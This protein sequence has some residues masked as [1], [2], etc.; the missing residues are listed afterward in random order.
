MKRNTKI[1]IILFFL[2]LFLVLVSV[3]TNYVLYNNENYNTST[4]KNEITN[5]K[6]DD[7]KKE[8]SG[9]ETT[10]SDINDKDIDNDGD[11]LLKNR[12]QY[13][14]KK[15]IAPIDPDDNVYNGPENMI[16]KYIEVQTKG[17][18]P[19]YLT[20]F[21]QYNI[22][23][24]TLSELDTINWDNMNSFDDIYQE[25]LTTPFTKELA[26]NVLRFRLDN[27]GVVLH[28]QSSADIY[29]EA[30]EEAKKKLSKEKYGLFLEVIEYLELE[31]EVESWQRIFG[32]NFLYD[33]A[34]SHATK[35]NM[36]SAQ[37]YFKNDN[38]MQHSIW[39]WRGDY[40]A[41]GSGAEIGIY[42]KIT[43]DGKEHWK[44]VDFEIPMTLSLYNYNNK[45]SINNVFSWNPV[46]KQWWITGFNTNYSNVDVAKQ[47]LI[48][49]LD[50]SEHKDMYESIK[51]PT[52][53][54]A[55][56][57]DYLYFDDS[58]YTIFICWYE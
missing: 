6:D 29:S 4:N 48:G 58:T 19:T 43:I 21:Y 52:V 3:G 13:I 24:K 14:N 57:K 5:K 50:F 36:R 17:N 9:S 31:K 51:E 8:D 25:L 38:L 28:S 34:F 32:Y 26:S 53:L 42:K 7:N 20:D 16:K 39:L 40:L 49:T 44:A 55:L 2:V 35:D 11:G 12:A 37:I 46:N 27:G 47:V 10:P 45:N 33:I 41:L 18:I 30:L 22:D 23:T 56:M 1:L 15:L 54:N